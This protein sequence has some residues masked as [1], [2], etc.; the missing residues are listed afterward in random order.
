MTISGIVMACRPEHL[1][2]TS[3]VVDR[4]DWAEVHYT[5]PYGRLV[6]TVEGCDVDESMDRLKELQKLPKVLSA[7]LSQFVVE[8]DNPGCAETNRTEN[9]KI[10][11]GRQS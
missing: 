1:G 4:F 5:D 10:E 8:D 3:A 9:L 11:V 2:E 6:I 7:E